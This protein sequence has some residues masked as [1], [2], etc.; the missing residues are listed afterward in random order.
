MQINLKLELIR[1][2]NFKMNINKVRKY[3]DII[4]YNKTICLIKLMNI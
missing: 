1:I 3:S 4:P 2:I